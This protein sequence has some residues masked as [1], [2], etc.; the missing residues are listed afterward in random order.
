MLKLNLD[1]LNWEK[2]FTYTKNVV[3]DET[4]LNQRGAKFQIVRFAPK[5]R[6]GPHFHKKVTEIFY[7]QQ[8]QGAMVFNGKVHQ[9]KKDDIFLCQPGDVHEIVN[10]SHEELV[11]LIFKTNERPEDIIWLAQKS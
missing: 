6:V 9:G 7:I 1:S 3:F 11:I 2:R 10:E 5:T 8:G 4:V